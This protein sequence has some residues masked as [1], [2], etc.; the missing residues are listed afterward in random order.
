MFFEA[1]IVSIPADLGAIRVQ[2]NMG[3]SLPEY[4]GAMTERLRESGFVANE[5]GVGGSRKDFVAG[6]NL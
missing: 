6:F 3:M 2:N 4:V 5:G 1:C